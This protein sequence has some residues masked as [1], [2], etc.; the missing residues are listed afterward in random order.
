MKS[1]NPDGEPRDE[2]KVDNTVDNTMAAIDMSYAE[3]L[4]HRDNNQSIY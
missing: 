3:L 4:D 2:S 1:S